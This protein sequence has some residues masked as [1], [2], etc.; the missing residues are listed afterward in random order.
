MLRIFCSSGQIDIFRSSTGRFLLYYTCIIAA[1]ACF[2]ILHTDESFDDV[3]YL[4]EI[5]E[6]EYALWIVNSP[7]FLGLI[8][9]GFN[10]IRNYQVLV[11]RLISTFFFNIAMVVLVLL[12]VSVVFI[13]LQTPYLQAICK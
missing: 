8:L 4:Y 5:R 6:G 2:L 10:A 12:V 13:C 11:N 7:V 3:S 9:T 1:F